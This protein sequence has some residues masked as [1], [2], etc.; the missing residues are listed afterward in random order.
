MKIRDW[1]APARIR[2]S[3]P[4]RRPASPRRLQRLLGET[5]RSRMRRPVEVDLLAGMQA[6]TSASRSSARSSPRHHGD[7]L[8]RFQRAAGIDRRVHGADRPIRVPSGP[9]TATRAD[10]RSRRSRCG[11]PRRGSDRR[12]RGRTRD[13]TLRGIRG[14]IDSLEGAPGA[15]SS[16]AALPHARRPLTAA[17]LSGLTVAAAHVKPDL[18][19]DQNLL[20]RQRSRR[21]PAWPRPG[22][23]ASPDRARSGRARDASTRCPRSRSSVHRVPVSRPA[24]QRLGGAVQVEQHQP[25]WRPAESVHAGDGLLASVAALVEMHAHPQ[26]PDLV[27]DRALVGVQPDPRNPGGDPQGLVRPA[28]G[29][30][31]IGQEPGQFSPRHEGLE[32]TERIV[33][34]SSGSDR[35]LVFPVARRSRN[36]RSGPRLR[37]AS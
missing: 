23:C 20:K 37:R 27:R 5:G 29:P 31:S 17:R 6:A 26:Y 14:R 33:Q 4:A 22:C 32:T 35:R 10:A 24:R 1:C 9:V 18:G 34:P 2:P 19:I 7:C 30:G 11:R 25:A 8:Q 3:W 13:A 36:R 16:V 21:R 12:R 15:E 28:A